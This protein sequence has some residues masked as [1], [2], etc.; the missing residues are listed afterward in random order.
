[1]APRKPVVV[2]TG[3]SRGIGLE[4]TRHLLNA[5][6]ANVVTISRT[7]TPELESLASHALSILECD[8]AD[9]LSLTEAIARAEEVHHHIDGLVLNAGTLDP[10]CR[11]GD[12]TPLAA[13]KHHFDVNFFSLVVA[14]KA[15]LPALRR[16]E[17][18]G[19]VVF[20]SSGAAVKGVAGWG[21]YNA[22]KAAMN[23]LSRTLA[24]EEPDVI[25][26]A[27]RPGMVDTDMQRRLRETG[28]QYMTEERYQFFV[29]THASG[30]LVKPEDVGK[31][32][33][34]ATHKPGLHNLGF[35]SMYID[36]HHHYFPSNLDKGKENSTLGWRTP[37]ANLPWTPEVSLRF[38][39][40]SNIQF[41]LLSFPALA[42]GAISDKNRA[43]ARERNEH[44]AG[45]CKKYPHRFGFFACLPFLDDT[46]VMGT[47][48]LAEIEYALDMLGAF[49]IS[50][51]SS[52]GEGPNAGRSATYT[53]T[54]KLTSSAYIGH[55]K[56]DPVWAELDRRQA[57]VFL[58]GTQTPSSTPYPHE[59]LG[60]PIVEVPNE[61][62]KAAA[63]LVVSG[64]KRKYSNVKV[65]LAHLGGSLP[66]L[67][68]RVAVLSQHMGC[69]LSPEEVLQSFKDFYYET[70]LSSYETTLVAMESFVKPD[71]I[72]FGTDFPGKLIVL[73]KWT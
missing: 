44:T 8:I 9:E 21:P 28:E 68:P 30:N 18:G 35:I 47:G 17:L 4:V 10:L 63:H 14:V 65:I 53:A 27:L 1:M 37:S 6:D 58:H 19:R 24:F 23:S 71:H 34:T 60:V 29:N 69:P 55:D 48:A 66:F 5:F 49:G 22:S 3:A 40:A 72:L 26:V 45:I 36:I 54:M 52:Y 62:F 50:L 25:S 42:S 59:Y 16:S 2:V 56:Y 43:L 73:W 38:M 64:H 70:A 51:S 67:A 11:V 41:A 7:K 31:F 13:W 12:G 33:T 20:I 39:D 32:S 46:E 15:A 57:I 61:T